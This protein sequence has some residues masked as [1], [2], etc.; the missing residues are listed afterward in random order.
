MPATSRGWAATDLAPTPKLNGKTNRISRIPAGAACGPPPSSGSATGG[1][2]PPHGGGEAA[3]AGRALHGLRRPL[4]PHRQADQRDGVGLP[5]QQP[6]PGVE[7]PGLP[8][9]LA[10]GPRPAAP[11]QQL[12]GIHGPRLPRS[13]RGVMRP[14]HQQHSGDDQEHRGL[15]HRPRLERGMG[16]PGGAEDADG[17]K[18]RRHRLGARGPRRRGTAQLRRAHRDGLRARDP[19]RAASSCTASRT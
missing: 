4:L 1:V 8:R 5:H 12:P 7:R 14:R 13:L 19:C 18:G 15:D 3:P 16:A 17:Q 9:P 10:G 11:D 6:D 2:P